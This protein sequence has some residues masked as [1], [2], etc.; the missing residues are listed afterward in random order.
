MLLARAQGGIDLNDVEGKCTSCF[1]L[2]C[3]LK[4]DVPIVDC[5]VVWT[6]LLYPP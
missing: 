6:R 5:H 2:R 3:K 1:L 4:S